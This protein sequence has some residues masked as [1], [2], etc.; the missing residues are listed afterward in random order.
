M[1]IIRWAELAAVLVGVLLAVRLKLWGPVVLLAVVCLAVLWF[2]LG[3]TS[4]MACPH[5]D[6]RLWGLSHKVSKLRFC[7]FCGR[8]LD[9]E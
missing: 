1:R 5:C 9:E 2:I 8:G 7:P 4:I 3:F 6:E